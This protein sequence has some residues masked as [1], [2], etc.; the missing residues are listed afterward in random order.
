MKGQNYSRKRQAIYD[1]LLST[2]EHPTA[3]WI[4]SNLKPIYPDLSLGTVYRNVKLL[5]SKGMVQSVTVVNGCERFDADVRPH[6]HFVCN[7]CGRVIDVYFKRNI[8]DL[9]GDLMLDGIKRVDSYSLIYY[10]ICENCET[11]EN[12]EN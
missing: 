12:T 6:S 8:T 10:G 9:T 11:V 1:L 2:K 7:G 3:D 4:Y 5:E